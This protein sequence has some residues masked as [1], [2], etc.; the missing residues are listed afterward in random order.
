MTKLL[1]TIL[2]KGWVKK[3]LDKLP[4]N[5]SK[6]IIGII[7]VALSVVSEMFPQYSDLLKSII[8]FIKENFQSSPVFSS[9][10]L[11]TVVGLWHKIEKVLDILVNHVT[12]EEQ[13]KDPKP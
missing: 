12:Q 6:T 11:I 5:G 8:E 4:A 10:V 2:G 7:L 3:L 13:G 1:W 9:G